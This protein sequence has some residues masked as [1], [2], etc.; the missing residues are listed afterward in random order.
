MPQFPSANQTHTAT[1]AAGAA[2]NLANHPAAELVARAIFTSRDAG[3]FSTTVNLTGYPAALATRIQTF[4]TTPAADGS[5]YT[6][7]NVSPDGLIFTIGW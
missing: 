4:L 7:S 6:V 1:V 5:S 2:F 3:V